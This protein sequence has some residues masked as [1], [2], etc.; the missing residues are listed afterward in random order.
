MENV[1]FLRNVNQGQRGQPRTSDLVAAFAA[2]GAG[3]IHP[4]QGNGTVLFDAAA[5]DQVVD[6][7]RLRLESAVGF[8]TVVFA[9]TLLFV[10]QIVEASADAA[11]LRRRE[12]TLFDAEATIADETA[13]AVQATKR[14]CAIVEHGAG[15]AVFENQVDRQSNG[16][17][18]LE[19]MLGTPATSRGLSTLVRLIDRFGR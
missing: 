4:F 13:A 7:V 19:A 9:R 6:D 17:P 2:A 1:A 14:R 16:T 3:E 18:A 12:L 11:G 8:A 15:W 10:E 5:P